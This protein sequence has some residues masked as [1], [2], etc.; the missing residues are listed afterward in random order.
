[1]RVTDDKFLPGYGT[2]ADA[3]AICHMSSIICH[4]QTAGAGWNGL[5]GQLL[6]FEG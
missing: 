1:M 3:R 5:A 2:I 4:F 6:N